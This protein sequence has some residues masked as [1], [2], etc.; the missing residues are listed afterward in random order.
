MHSLD[1]LGYVPRPIREYTAFNR[2][3]TGLQRV[4]GVNSDKCLKLKLVPGV[5]RTPLMKFFRDVQR[6][7]G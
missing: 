2:V 6:V 7:S 1:E 4:V 5:K 3:S